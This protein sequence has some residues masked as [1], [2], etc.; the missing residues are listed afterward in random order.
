[1]SDATEEVESLVRCFE[2]AALTT[3]EDQ[4]FHKEYH[5]FVYKELAD[6]YKAVGLAKRAASQAQSDALGYAMYNTR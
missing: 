3:K 2:C 1:M 6:L 5:A 4:E